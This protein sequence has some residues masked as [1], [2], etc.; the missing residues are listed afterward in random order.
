M[1]VKI[2]ANT[3]AEDALKAVEFGAD[4][5]GFVFAPSKRQVTAAQAARISLELPAGVERVGV[6][7]ADSAEQ[8]ATIAEAAG[9]TAVQLHGGFDP[10]RTEE[11]E[12]LLD[13]EVCIIETAHWTVGDDEASAA[14]VSG[15]LAQIADYSGCRRVLIDAKVGDATGGTGVSFAWPSAYA[16]LH[17][18]P[19]LRIVL[20]GGLHPGNVAEA[21]RVLRPW[22]VDVASG[23]ESEPGRKN[24]AKLKAFVENA[25]GAV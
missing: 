14:R 21:I 18:Q 15:R 20:A 8:I 19:D 23:V 6:F 1:W 3:S 12:Q 7:A 2:C 22:G 25:R 4:A 5:V 13:P 17:S 10:A 9:L 24:L 16:A 11:L